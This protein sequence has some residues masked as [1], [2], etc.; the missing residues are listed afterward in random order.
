M[1]DPYYN[2]SYGPGIE[3]FMNWGNTITDGW[4]ANA[5]LFFVWVTSTYV[6]SKSEWKLS[7][8]VAFSFFICLISAMIIRVFTIVNSLAIYIILFG[9]AGSIFWMVIEGR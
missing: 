5:F 7:G 1:A 6:L 4:M 3:G 9:L 2:I 8:V